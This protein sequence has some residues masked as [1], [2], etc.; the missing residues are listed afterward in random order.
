MRTANTMRIHTPEEHRERLHEMVKAAPAVMVLSCTTARGPEGRL[1]AL[2]QTADDT[3]MYVAASLDRVQAA[4]LARGPRVTVVVPGAGL[5]VFTAEAQI[6]RD[7]RLVDDLWTNAWNHWF[8]GKSDPSLAIVILTPIEGSYW[9]AMD[10]HSYVY[11]LMSPPPPREYD[12]SGIP[13]EV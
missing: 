5:A 10:Q 13:T 3:T 6:S 1:M 11:R 7:R 2:V 4:E 9:D 8:R 12:S